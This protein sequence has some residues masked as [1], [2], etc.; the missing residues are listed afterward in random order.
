MHPPAAFPQLPRVASPSLGTLI[1]IQ[2]LA[3]VWLMTRAGLACVILTAVVAAACGNSD[4]AS[5]SPTAPTTTAPPA[6]TPTP[7]PTTSCAPPAVT[8]LAVTQ[9]GSS[10]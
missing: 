3:G 10:T 9:T 4:S 8:G 5:P 1:A 2:P 6:T 7:S